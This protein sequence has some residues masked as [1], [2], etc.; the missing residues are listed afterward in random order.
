MNAAARRWVGRALER[1]AALKTGEFGVPK[2]TREASSDDA[3]ADA[4]RG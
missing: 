2:A 4:D 3:D 1:Q